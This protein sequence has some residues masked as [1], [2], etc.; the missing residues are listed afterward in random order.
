M[1]RTYEDAND[2]HLVLC[3]GEGQHSPCLERIGVPAGS[4]TVQ[5]PGSR[6]SYVAFPGW[7]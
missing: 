6:T 2:S 5:A 1:A 4:G 3:N 7:S